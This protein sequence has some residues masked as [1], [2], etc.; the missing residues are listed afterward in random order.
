MDQQT[1]QQSCSYSD[2][3]AK[4]ILPLKVMPISHIGPC[5]TVTGI[6]IS[7]LKVNADDDISFNIAVDPPY[8]EML[9]LGNLDPSHST[10]SGQHGIHIE[11]ICR[12]P[13]GSPS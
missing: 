9:G 10:L 3:T 13:L 12:E 7:G 2:S 11:V 1:Q 8:E 6:V 4:F 5:V